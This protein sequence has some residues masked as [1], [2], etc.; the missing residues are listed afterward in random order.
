M[1]IERKRFRVSRAR[2]TTALLMLVGSGCARVST[3]LPLDQVDGGNTNGGA[4]TSGA[5]GGAANSG[6]IAGDFSTSAGA[7][8]IAGRGGDGGPADSA[9]AAGA[10]GD[11]GSA[12]VGPLCEQEFALC[13][14]QTQC[15]DLR[16][17]DAQG[18]AV[19]NCG[20][21]DNTCSLEH[22]NGAKCVAGTCAPTCQSGFADCN[23]TA[24]N[25]GCETATTTIDNCGGCRRICSTFGATSRTCSSGECA[26]KCAPHFGDCKPDKGGA[27]DDGCETYL[28]SLD[29]CGSDCIAK[30]ACAA[31]EV[32]ND[33]SCVAPSGVAVLSVPL[34][35]PS[36]IQRFADLLN[37]GNEIALEGVVLTARV[38]APGAQGGVVLL[39][40]SDINSSL[41]PS[42][43]TNLASISNK[44][45]DISIKIESS[46]AFNAARTKQINFNVSTTGAVANPMVIYVDSVRTSNLAINDTFDSSYGNFVKSGLIKVEDSTLTWAATVP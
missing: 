20:F 25:D 5:S 23:P 15:T 42:V 24:G 30:V 34:A 37:F 7:S 45:T 44:W 4:G 31:T 10:T 41:G 16:V 12:G 8:P 32:C 18:S 36:E 9:G 22:A 43:G 2:L 21:C 27:P 11:G 33:G 6:G 1:L 29:Q 46:G 38:Y 17:G 14:G 13:T 39:Y 19:L 35:G 28:D 3:E 40:A 26:P